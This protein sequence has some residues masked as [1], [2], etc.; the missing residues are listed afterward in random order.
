MP[1]L[2]RTATAG[3]LDTIRRILADTNLPDGGVEEQFGEGYSVAMQNGETIGCAGIEVYGNYGLLRSV[4][5]APS[6]QGKG[7]AKRV[8]EDRLDW[9]R[10][11]KLCALYLL[12]DTAEDY[13][14]RFGFERIS[15]DDA[16]KEIQVSKEFSEVCC[17][18]AALL[19]LRLR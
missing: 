14:P 11:R 3:D 4:A 7:I 1:F 19:V 13:F 12:T 18:S 5:V 6:H 15:R 9:A 2:I 16:P 10:E 17:E 8:V